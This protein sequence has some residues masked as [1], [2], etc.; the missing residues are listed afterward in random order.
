MKA[1]DRV[2]PWKIFGAELLGTAL[3]VAVG[4]SI[5]IF[6]FGHGSPLVQWLPGAMWRR[7]I[8]GFFFGT[9]GMA[10]TL[11]PLGKES[12]A[13]IN[14]IVTLGFWMMGR[15]KT[16][17]ALGYVL[18]Q[19]IGAIV[20]AAPLLAWGAIGRSVAYGA[21][22]P[23]PGYGVLA[24]L[25]GEAVA[26]F[27]LIFG[28]FFFLR[29][30]TLRALTPAL[31]PPLYAVMVWLEAPIS[32]TSTNPARS[33]GPAVISGDWKGWWIYWAGPLIG[34]VIAVAIHRW[35]GRRWLDIAVAKIHHFEHDPYGVFHF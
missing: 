27:V 23:G 18:S 33:L 34:T 9:T 25:L 7:L 30:K 4:L 5:V 10:I 19:L 6:D 22:A 24:A 26:S 31:F 11:S 1:L 13:H 28:V 12:G 15:L 35:A 14:P 21:T 32:G 8:T 29:H 3:L 17:H 2:F 20:G 16:R